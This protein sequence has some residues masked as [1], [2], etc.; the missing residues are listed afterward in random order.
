[1]LYIQHQFEDTYY[2]AAGDWRFELAAL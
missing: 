1:M 2:E